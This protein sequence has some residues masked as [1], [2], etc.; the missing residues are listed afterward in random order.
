MK[1]PDNGAQIRILHSQ[2]ITNHKIKAKIK[3]KQQIHRVRTW[4]RNEE[5]RASNGNHE[6]ETVKMTIVTRCLYTHSEFLRNKWRSEREKENRQNSEYVLSGDF[7]IKICEILNL[8]E[9]K[10]VSCEMVLQCSSEC[11]NWRMSKIT[12]CV[13]CVTYGSS[14]DE[15][16]DEEKRKKNWIVW[17]KETERWPVF[18]N[19]CALP[20]SSCRQVFSRLHAQCSRRSCLRSLAI[21]SIWSA[22]HIIANSLLHWYFICILHT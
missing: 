22:A 16:I 5:S 18:K 12:P 15:N 19:A 17:V 11:A 14:N 6:K 8:I 13:R 21:S 7:H 3:R 4:E 2:T 10:F 20:S 9:I 1:R